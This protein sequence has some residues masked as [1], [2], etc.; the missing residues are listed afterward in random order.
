MLLEVSAFLE[1]DGYHS[2]TF[3]ITETSNVS[4]YT[5]SELDTYGIIRDSEE[6]IVEENDDGDIDYNFYINYTL[7]PG[8]YTIE[9]S[10]Y[11]ETETGPYELHVV[12][13]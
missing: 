12:K 2:Y 10:G 11:D 8:T 5:I 7:D 9:V 13:N 6:N 3:T 1:P 4:I